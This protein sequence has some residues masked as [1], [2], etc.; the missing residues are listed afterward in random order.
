MDIQWFGEVSPLWIFYGT[1]FFSV[2]IILLMGVM[3]KYHRAY[4]LISGYNT[5]SREKKANVD[6]V[7]LSKFVG[8]LCF[9]I[10]AIFL[11][12][13]ILFMLEEEVWGGMAL[14]LTAPISIYAVIGSQRYDGNTRNPDGTMKMSSKLV[15]GAISG[16]LV[17]VFVGVGALL[18]FGAQP[19]QFVI[20]DEYFWIKGLYGER[21]PFE[22]ISN[23]TLSEE[24]PKIIFRSNGSSVGAMKKG[25]FKMEDIGG[26]KLFVNTSIPP[27]IYIRKENKHIFL[28]CGSEEET[29]ELFRDLTD[30]NR[31]ERGWN[32]ER[33][34]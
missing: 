15:I 9:A 11:M 16:F 27:F 2:F 28:N 21:I 14:V 23:I 24:L 13:T 29:R 12:G 33:K 19:A 32:F 34:R 4:W 26:A 8:N 7:G 17:L 1:M 3:V 31:F 6:V 25:N 18:Y 30:S 5:M 20:E 22:D 10:A